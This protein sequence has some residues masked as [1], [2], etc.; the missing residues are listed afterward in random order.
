MLVEAKFS[1]E[2][3][4]FKN[5]KGFFDIKSEESFFGTEDFDFGRIKVA[6]GEF[7]VQFS[8]QWIPCSW[9]RV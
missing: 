7:S 4:G 6:K 3:T 2:F 8:V 9:I 5:M 1:V